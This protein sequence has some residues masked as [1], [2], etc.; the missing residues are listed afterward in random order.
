MR[1]GEGELGIGVGVAFSSEEQ[2]AALGH[3]HVSL[4]L[5]VFVYLRG[6][7]GDHL[8]GGRVPEHLVVVSG[9]SV[10]EACGLQIPREVGVRVDGHAVVLVGVAVLGEEFGEAL[11][12]REFSG[13]DGRPDGEH[14]DRGID[15]LHL[16]VVVDESGVGAGVVVGGE[17]QA[18]LGDLP[19]PAVAEVDRAAARVEGVDAVVGRR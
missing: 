15:G 17:L 13:L 11:S 9:P 2:G 16:G 10:R 3:R 12:A 1:H 4:V 8:G 18:L 19:V 7:V 14:V 6:E 5:A